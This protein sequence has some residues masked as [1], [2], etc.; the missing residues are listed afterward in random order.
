M[1]FVVSKINDAYSLQCGH[2]FYNLAR[3][4]MHMQE[5]FND[6]KAVIEQGIPAVL[7][8]VTGTSGSTPRKAGSKMLVFQDGSIKGTIGGGNLEFQVIREAVKNMSS[9]EPFSKS[10]NLEDDLKMQ[11][12]G[13]MQVYFEPIGCLPKLYIFGGGHIGKALAGY[14]TGLGFHPFIFDQREGIFDGLNL[15]GVETQNGDLLQIIETLTFD[16]NTYIAVVT[17]RHDFDEKVLT[18]CLPLEFAYLGM[19]GSQRKIAEIRKN[20]LEIHSITESQLN[21][22]D[23]PIGI[24]FAAETP[25]E[26]AISIVAKMIDVKNT[27]K[28]P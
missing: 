9:G 14:A 27:L 3:Y 18:A 8:V 15:P 23:M 26:I 11:C 12:G 24:P 20:A 22:V 21:K 25:A 2:L 6:L 13:A 28:K 5:I 17:H 19:I 4:F 16:S 7:C 10:F 1:P